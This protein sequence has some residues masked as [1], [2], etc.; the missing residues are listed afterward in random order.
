MV[1]WF[2]GQEHDACS[3]PV[4]EQICGVG[5]DGSGIDV[6]PNELSQT[7]T[8]VRSVLVMGINTSA[9]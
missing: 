6:A 9:G 7:A 1:A 5:S 3:C 4:N 2:G 8:A